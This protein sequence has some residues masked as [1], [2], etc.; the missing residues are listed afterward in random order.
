MVLVLCRSII[1]IIFGIVKMHMEKYVSSTDLD[2]V[3]W[4]MKNAHT[5]RHHPQILLSS[6]NA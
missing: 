1:K 3:P 2:H 5:N 4:K 6:K